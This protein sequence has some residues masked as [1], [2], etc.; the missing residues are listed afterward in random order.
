MTNFGGT[1]FGRIT[2]SAHPAHALAVNPLDGTLYVA[3]RNASDVGVYNS[4][5]QFLKDLPVGF[6]PTALAFEQ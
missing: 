2:S 4:Q 3:F 5:N 1:S 6:N